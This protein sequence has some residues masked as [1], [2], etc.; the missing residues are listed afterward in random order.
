MMIL[1]MYTIDLKAGARIRLPGG[2]CSE[3]IVLHDVVP[4]GS[5]VHTLYQLILLRRRRDGGMQEGEEVG[6]GDSRVR[7]WGIEGR[8]G[9]KRERCRTN[10]GWMEEIG[11]MKD[12]GMKGWRTEEGWR[13]LTRKGRKKERRRSRRNSWGDDWD[14][15]DT[16]QRWRALKGMHQQSTPHTC[17][18]LWQIISVRR[19]SGESKAHSVGSMMSE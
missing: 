2:G 12:R 11:G 3:V 16:N 17:A 5:E 7:D 19:F 18:S 6:M 9:G 1:I 13:G 15:V 8:A 10:E 14:N 4:V